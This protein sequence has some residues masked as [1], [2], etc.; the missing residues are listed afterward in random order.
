MKNTLLTLEPPDAAS[1]RILKR[2]CVIAAVI[3]AV[4]LLFP[5]PAFAANPLLDPA[6]WLKED[7]LKPAI[8]GL[9]NNFSQYLSSMT[10]DNLLTG[11]FTSLFSSN[12]SADTLWSAITAVHQTLLVPLGESILALVM[13]VQVVKIS[14]KIDAQATLPTVKEILFLAVFYVIFHWLIVNSVDICAAVYDEINKI[15]V[16]LAGNGSITGT[17][18]LGDVT[19]ADLGTMIIAFITSLFVWMSGLLV[20]I[21]AY[22]MAG[23]RAIQLYVM[24][25]FSPIPFSLMGFEETR[26]FGVNFCKNFLAVCLA[27]AIMVFLI[28]V[29]PV[30]YA[31]V[32]GSTSMIDAGGSFAVGVI[33]KLIGL[34]ILLILGLIK[35]G[36]WSRDLLGG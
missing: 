1:R 23:A 33:A 36:S 22:V 21:I 26:S 31:A 19:N 20:A 27:G 35:S 12:G 5:M 28:V 11:N 4:M 25:V 15:S 13:L 6:G 14:Q 24:A 29:F 17:V 7:V 18:S 32:I 30:L 2:A 34:P 8:E 3:A 10:T 9:L 16:A